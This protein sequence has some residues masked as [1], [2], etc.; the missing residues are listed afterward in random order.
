M[1]LCRTS[2]HHPDNGRQDGRTSRRQEHGHTI[3][4]KRDMIQ[5][6]T[7]GNGQRQDGRHLRVTSR[8]TPIRTGNHQDGRQTYHTPRPHERPHIQRACF[9]HHQD[10]R[11]N[12]TRQTAGHPDNGHPDGNGQFI[13]QIED[14][15]HPRQH[16]RRNGHTA[17]HQAT[18]YLH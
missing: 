9:R 17:T 5:T 12:G 8:R 14:Y 16:I 15:T 18:P 3:R 10:G 11:G 2:A 6:A 13:D 1:N 4:N 7:N